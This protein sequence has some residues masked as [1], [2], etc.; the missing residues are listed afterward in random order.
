[1]ARKLIFLLAFVL[2]GLG[3]IFTLNF[4]EVSTPMSIFI[5]VGL[6]FYLSG[7]YG[8]YKELKE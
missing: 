3:L 1:M 6:F 2:T 8:H 7:I 4:E 5:V